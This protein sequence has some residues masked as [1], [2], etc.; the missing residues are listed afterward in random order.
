MSDKGLENLKRESD[1]EDLENLPQGE[2]NNECNR[3]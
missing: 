2:E 1:R 3:K